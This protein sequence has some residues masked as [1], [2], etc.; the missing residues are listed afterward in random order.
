[1][2]VRT[3]CS[4]VDLELAR[5]FWNH[6]SWDLGL[7]MRLFDAHTWSTNTCAPLPVPAAFGYAGAVP[8]KDGKIYMI[9]GYPPLGGIPSGEV[10]S[11]NW[12]TCFYIYDTV[13][14]TW[15]VGDPLPGGQVEYGYS[16]IISNDLWV[17][18]G[19]ISWNLSGSGY[20]LMS[21]AVWKHSLTNIVVSQFKAP[22]SDT[23]GI[24]DSWEQQYFGGITNANPN[25]ICSNGINTVIQSYVAGINP[26]DSAA[27]FSITNYTRN[28]L[29]WDA[30]SGRVYN[31]YWTT[32]LMNSFQP[33]QINYT[34]GVI[35]DSLHSAAS[36]CFY[37]IEVR[38]AP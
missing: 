8:V 7:G 5:Q 27:R 35:T 15:A 25:A 23:D 26:T 16:A 18:G 38:L 10:N 6:E 31:V 20:D 32:N 11:T 3:E 17:V 30:V 29:Q 36:K 2:T 33:L 9:G 24:P 28:V 4:G 19:D 21:G 34:G 22:D 13:A 12:A 14:N 1:M 37:K